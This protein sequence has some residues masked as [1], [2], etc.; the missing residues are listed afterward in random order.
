MFDQV[1]FLSELPKQMKKKRKNF[2]L[3]SND[4]KKCFFKKDQK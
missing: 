2:F 3:N 4:T 1:V